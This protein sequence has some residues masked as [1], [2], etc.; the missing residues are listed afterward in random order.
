MN[1]RPTCYCLPNQV[2]TRRRNRQQIEMLFRTHGGRR[3]GAGRKRVLPGKKRVSHRARESFSSRTPL[4]ITTGIRQDV[5]RLRNRTRCRVIRDALIAVLDEPGF[6]VCEFSVQRSHLHL[7]CEAED[8]GCLG[9]GMKRLKKRIA[10]GINRQLGRKGS[11]FADRY[12]LEVLRCPRQTRNAI[13]YVMHNARRHGERLPTMYGGV[14]PFSSAWWF[15]GWV[16]AGWR[17]GLAPPGIR[18]TSGA[19][20]WLLRVGWKRSGLLGLGELPAAATR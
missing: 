7:V 8:K 5:P 16:D 17:A 13:C 1:V 9:R 12:H 14:D 15:E 4:H 2:A 18:C 10:N 19:Q 6:R 20:S 11:V 3:A